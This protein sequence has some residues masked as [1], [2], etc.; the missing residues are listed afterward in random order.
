MHSQATV[1]RATTR[2][3]SIVQAL[4]EAIR[5]EMRRD[6]DVFVIGEDIRIGG[7]F[8]FT[9]GLLDDFGRSSMLRPEDGP[10]NSHNNRTQD[11]QDYQ[12]RN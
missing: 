6:E 8:L 11:R 12:C 7:S 4:R 5:E 10:K 3:L 2:D 1:Q 9:L